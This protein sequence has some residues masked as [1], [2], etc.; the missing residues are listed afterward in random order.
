MNELAFMCFSQLLENFSLQF[1][2]YFY[3]ISLFQGLVQIDLIYN[4]TPTPTDNALLQ[5]MLHNMTH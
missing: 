2:S 3:N 5:N 4:T 1:A